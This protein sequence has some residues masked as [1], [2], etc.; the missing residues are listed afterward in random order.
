MDDASTAA[1]IAT[2]IV[3]TV[4]SISSVCPAR[5]AGPTCPVRP[6]SASADGAWIASTTRTAVPQIF[7]GPT[8][9][10]LW[11]TGVTI[12]LPAALTALATTRKVRSFAAAIPGIPAS[13]ARNARSDISS[14]AIGHV[15]FPIPAP[16]T[17]DAR[18]STAPAPT[19]MVCR[20]AETVAAVTIFPGIPALPIR[21]VGRILVTDTGLAMIPKIGSSAPVTPGMTAKDA[22]GAPPG[23]RITATGNAGP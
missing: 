2:A 11:A 3:P 5:P 21:S 12:R 18:S 10:Y 15:A 8:S 17:Q 16:E 6:A 19:R 1:P 22:R 9:A 13:A 23:L 14:T 7:A 20:C 4:V